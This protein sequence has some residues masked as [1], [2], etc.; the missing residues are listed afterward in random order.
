MMASVL[1]ILV[2]DK[3]HNVLIGR[4]MKQN[5]IVKEIKIFFQLWQMK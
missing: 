5:N 2:S 1:N 4:D 3:V